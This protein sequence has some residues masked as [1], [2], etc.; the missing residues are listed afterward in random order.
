M[1][2][3]DRWAD[4]RRDIERL[5]GLPLKATDPVTNT[6]QTIN[7]ALLD[8]ARR[9]NQ[10]FITLAIKEW[11]DHGQGCFALFVQLYVWQCW[12]RLARLN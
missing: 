7:L 8:D 6:D 12:R 1:L 2:N 5:L 10:S 11:D 9:R 3:Q 4:M